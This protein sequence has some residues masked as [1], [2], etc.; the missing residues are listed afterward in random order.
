[1][2]EDTLEEELLHEFKGGTLTINPENKLNND[3]LIKVESPDKAADNDSA[4]T[5]KNVN[6]WSANFISPL[7]SIPNKS[8]FSTM[9][10]DPCAVIF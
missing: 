1:M 5:N 6:H 8:K 4:K 10:N 9:D 7:T 2:I 3:K